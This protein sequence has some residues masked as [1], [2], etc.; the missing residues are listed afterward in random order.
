[1]AAAGPRPRT[2]PGRG[3]THRGRGSASSPC[4][5]TREWLAREGAA[6]E[7]NAALGYP[8]G[9]TDVT[10]TIEVDVAYCWVDEWGNAAR[11]QADR[12]L[13]EHEGVADTD[14]PVPVDVPADPDVERAGVSCRWLNA[15]RHTA[16]VQERCEGRR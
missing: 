2:P 8:E 11:P 13:G 5:S 15:D 16:R 4:S 3:R 7:T 1:M 12:K 9:I 6:D 10:G 14:R